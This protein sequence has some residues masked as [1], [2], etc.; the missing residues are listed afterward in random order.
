[1]KKWQKC[2]DKNYKRMKKTSKHVT[3]SCARCKAS[4]AKARNFALLA[5]SVKLLHAF[6][7]FGSSLVHPPPLC[8][9]FAFFGYWVGFSLWKSNVLQVVSLLRTVFPKQ[10]EQ[11]SWVDCQK[12]CLFKRHCCSTPF[13]ASA[14]FIAAP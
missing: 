8:P 9:A 1:M 11:L 14:A 5:S 10:H 2:T 7:R 3:L 6:L 4:W 12:Q 13:A